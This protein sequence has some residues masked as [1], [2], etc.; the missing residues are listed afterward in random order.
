MKLQPS[1][2]CK[3]RTTTLVVWYWQQIIVLLQAFPSPAALAASV[4]AYL[5][6]DSSTDAE[7]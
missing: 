4:S 1:V 5:V 6:Q 7:S 3:D 2:S